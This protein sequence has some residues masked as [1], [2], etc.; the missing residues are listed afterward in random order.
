[1]L[2]DELKVNFTGNTN[3]ILDLRD[4]LASNSVLNANKPNFG[5]IKMLTFFVLWSN[6]GEVM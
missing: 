2:T 5:K 3:F 6:L 1:M 4:Y